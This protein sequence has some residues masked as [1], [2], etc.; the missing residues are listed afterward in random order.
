MTSK[1]YTGA[2]L[3]SAAFILPSPSGARAGT[4]QFAAAAND[5]ARNGA[6]S[7][8]ATPTADD[9]GDEGKS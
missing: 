3:A 9:E 6:C 4:G 5:C 7:T 2:L 1:A 8:G